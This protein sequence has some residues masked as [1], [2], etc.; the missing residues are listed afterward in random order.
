M[1]RDN[2]ANIK[3]NQWQCCLRKK[4][5]IMNNIFKITKLGEVR[6][7]TNQK[8]ITSH[9]RDIQL[10]QLGGKFADRFTS[11]LFDAEAE[12]ELEE[13]ALV[14]AQLYFYTTEYNE[15]VFQNVSIS[16]IE[17]INKKS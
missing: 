14:A 6:P 11:T 17:I 2:F 15:R 4:N 12:K 9:C 3:T 5:I 16:D 8:E 1:K 13:G 7:Y 10:Q